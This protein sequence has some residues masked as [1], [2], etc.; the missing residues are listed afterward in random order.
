LTHSVYGR[1]VL[2]NRVWLTPFSAPLESTRSPEA[3]SQPSE[4]QETF[5]HDNHGA[6]S[7]RSWANSAAASVW[8]SSNVARNCLAISVS[9]SCRPAKQAAL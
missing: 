6:N 4:E 2:V 9:Y 7:S 5:G 8:V 1:K 3:N